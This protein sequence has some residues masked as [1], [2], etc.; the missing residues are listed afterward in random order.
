MSQ[1]VGRSIY[2]ELTCSLQI[3]DYSGMSVLNI[4]DSAYCGP[5]NIMRL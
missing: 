5:Q 4:L 3:I 1:N 2:S